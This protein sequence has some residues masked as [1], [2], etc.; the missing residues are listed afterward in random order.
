MFALCFYSS[1]WVIT[2]KDIL[3]KLF[4]IN[5]GVLCQYRV[6]RKVV[7]VTL[8]SLWFFCV[9]MTTTKTRLSLDSPST[10]SS[11]TAHTLPYKTSSSSDPPY[12]D[13]KIKLKATG[14]AT[15][16]KK[17]L[18]RFKKTGGRLDSTSL[19]SP[20]TSSDTAPTLP[21]K[22]SGSVSSSSDPPY[23]DPKIKLKATG[24]VAR[25]L[26]RFQKIGRGGG[27]GKF[28]ILLLL[29]L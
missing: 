15:G 20:S 13:P 10:Y 18:T 12:V 7:S 16:F 8:I 4:R 27:L 6:N 25:A 28:V 23:V 11:D 5:F 26:N 3:R 22:T 21:D 9:Q 2:E 29:L 1:K 19:D 14:M 17:M 24:I